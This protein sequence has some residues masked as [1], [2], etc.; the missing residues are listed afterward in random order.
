MEVVRFALASVMEA[1]AVATVLW[2]LEGRK[3]D[4][5]LIYYAFRVSFGFQAFSSMFAVRFMSSIY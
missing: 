5:H 3:G 4:M 1:E 2:R